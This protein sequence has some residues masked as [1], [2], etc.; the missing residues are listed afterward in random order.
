MVELGP[1]IFGP[2]L[3]L[4]QYLQSKGLLASNMTCPRCS[5]VVMGIAGD[6]QAVTRLK[7]S[8]TVVFFSK[9]RLPLFKWVYLMQRWSRQAPSCD[10]RI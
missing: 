7:V 10:R 3:N 5:L 8:V 9:S 4:I 6:V 1:V 2:K